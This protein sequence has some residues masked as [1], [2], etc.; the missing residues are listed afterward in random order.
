MP[1]PALSAVTTQKYRPFGIHFCGKDPDR[2][3]GVFAELGRVDFLDVGWGG[4]VAKLRRSLPDAFL[5]IRLSPVEIIE[6]S[7]SEIEATIRRLVADSGNPQLTGV[8]CINIDEK[9]TDDKI[10]CIF[11]TVAAIRGEY[12]N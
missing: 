5:N 4:N 2:Y 1:S 12:S 6:Q 10:T 3:G 11:E 7:T 8:C 9:V